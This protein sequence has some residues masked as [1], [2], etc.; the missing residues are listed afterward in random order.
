LLLVAITSPSQSAIPTKQQKGSWRMPEV[1]SGQVK[2]SK[3]EP[4]KS[5]KARRI[6]A[7]RAFAD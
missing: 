1:R 3:W 7:N 2:S 4:P 6:A 5:T